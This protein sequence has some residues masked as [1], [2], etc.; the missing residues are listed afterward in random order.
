MQYSNL[1]AGYNKGR[2]V[3]SQAGMA[4]QGGFRKALQSS[5][6]YGGIERMM[7]NQSARFGAAGALGMFALGRGARGARDMRSGHLG[8]GLR[9]GAMAA[10]AGYMA[11][12]MIRNP[13][14]AA[15][16]LQFGANMGRAGMSGLRSA[17]KFLR[18]VRL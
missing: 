11:Y 4:F 17:A 13:G 1:G 18:G 3:A 14:L 7:G 12:N 15:N 10:G 8:R 16:H 2:E 9:N 6:T 5:H